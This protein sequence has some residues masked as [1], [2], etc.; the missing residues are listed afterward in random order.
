MATP[1]SADGSAMCLVCCAQFHKYRCPKCYV[2]Y[3][4][5]ACY[6]VHSEGC[7]EAFYRTNA[8]EELQGSYTSAGDTRKMREI[9]ERVHQMDIEGAGDAAQG[10]TPGS[11]A[12]VEPDA[13]A[14]ALDRLSPG[15][16]EAILSEVRAR[17]DRCSAVQY[18]KTSASMCS[19]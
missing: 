7:T 9:L 8:V 3:C 14:A 16:L 6:K 5:A 10:T 1:G 15:T 19:A 4:S 13:V 2:K 18:S 17:R 11:D 12:A